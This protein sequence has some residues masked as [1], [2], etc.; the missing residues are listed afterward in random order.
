VCDL[1]ITTLREVDEKE[2]DTLYTELEAWASTL[3]P[4]TQRSAVISALRLFGHFGRPQA[5][6]WLFT[7]VGPGQPGSVRFP[8]LVALL[9]CLRGQELRKDE[10]S[11]LL[12]ILEEP[13]F[14]DS[15]RL[16]L[17][18][19]DAQTLPPDTQ[20]LLSKLVE[21]P[22]TAV[23]KF[24]LRKLGEFGS[25]AVVRTLVEQL[26]DEDASRRDAATRALRKIPT[27]RTMLTKEFLTCDDPRKAWALA[28][29]LPTYEGKWRQDTLAGI[30]DRLR[31]ALD[32]EERIHGAYLHLL[33][34]VDS[35][36]VYTQLAAR[37]AQL[38][39]GKHYKEAVRVLSL[40][41]D[42]PVFAPE[43]KLRL[44]VAQLK[45]HP[46]AVVPQAQR[47][48]PALELLA[49]LSRSS[50]FPILDV[51]K[52]DTTLKPEDLFYV[53]FCFAERSGEERVL[54]EGILEVLA[55]RFPRSKVGKSAK[56]KLK[57][58]GG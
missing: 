28:E 10:R 56:N 36:Y 51:L 8:A 42:F 31:A 6:T 33:K 5:R 45:L 1:I 25:P 44:A 12:A 34:N 21:S 16:T 15:V 24:A 19:L 30:W 52:K 14:S 3:D 20:P 9:H 55:A 46:H 37:G 13:Q 53:G 23:Q 7:F 43:D 54:G 32:R 48:E 17:D 57:L 11:R 40:L 47:Q 41:R 27:A 58:L 18:L 4:Q 39:K 22:H 29:V 26:G 2:Q 49:D 38:S 50:T 35:E